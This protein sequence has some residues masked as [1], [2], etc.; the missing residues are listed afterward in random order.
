MIKNAFG[1]L[2]LSKTPR[3]ANYLDISKRSN[4][5]LNIVL[6][7]MAIGAL[8]PLVFIFIISF[9]SESSITTKGY[10]FIPAEWSLDAYRYILANVAPIVEAYKISLLVTGVGT[11]LGLF[12]C[13][14]YAYS[15]SR[16]TFK[17]RGL[18]T[19]IALIP[20]LFSGGMVANYLVVTNFL[21]LRD[22]YWSLILPLAMSPFY[23][24]VLRT[25]F[26]I[27]IPEAIIEAA[28][29]DGA[30][31]IYAF[32]KIAIPISKPGL[33]TIGL[34]LTLDYWNNWFNAMLYIDTPSK[35]PIQY[36][37]V[38]IE[39]SIQFMQQNASE[40]GIGAGGALPAETAKM[41]I[42]VLTVLPILLAYPFFQK[43]FVSGLTLG[44]VKD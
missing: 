29:I 25:F 20:M 11:I 42:V 28:K 37:L 4:I 9:T 39:N 15:L 17:L 8:I 32:V 34:F 14:T 44:A 43:Y 22:S 36:F 5:I 12:L 26:K 18:F 35:V 7:I 27:T 38:R 3:E 33:A 13:A 24:I 31:E 41:A 1:K 23:I 21:G 16:N 30:S 19:K 2:R 10:S 40:M 6:W